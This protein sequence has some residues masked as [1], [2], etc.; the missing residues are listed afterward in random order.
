M[1]NGRHRI[2]HLLHR[3]PD[4]LPRAGPTP[5]GRGLCRTN[6]VEEMPTLRVVELKRLRER[7][8]HG[9]GGTRRI[10]ALESGVVVDADAGEQRDLLAAK[11]GDAARAAAV[12]AEP[13]LLRRDPRAP[14]GQELA[15]LVPRVHAGTVAPLSSG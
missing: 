3:R 13:R 8:E 11:A 5:C 2:E 9:V 14:R 12:G 4:L 1:R 15:D 7:F 10:A 6:E